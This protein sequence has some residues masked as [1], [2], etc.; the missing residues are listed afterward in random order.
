[1][2]NQKYELPTEDNETIQKTKELIQ[3]IAQ[4]WSIPF[5]KGLITHW[6]RFY[7]LPMYQKSGLVMNYAS[8]AQA[9]ISFWEDLLRIKSYQDIEYSDRH[10]R[11]AHIFK[12]I[13]HIRPIKASNDHC[14]FD[15]IDKSRLQANAFFALA[16]AM[17][18]LECEDFT[19]GE[20]EYIIYSSMYRDIHAR[21]WSMIFYLL[22]KQHATH[23]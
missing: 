16:C 5:T 19:P 12:W 21:E 11:A 15:K 20:N 2:H 10:K 8:L 7:C 14:D 4:T 3:K 13:S 17:A 1:V 23:T 18:F 6:K 22:E 9:A